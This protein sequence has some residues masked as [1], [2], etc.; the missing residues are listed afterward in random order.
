M[1]CCSTATAS[2]PDIFEGTRLVADALAHGR[3]RRPVQ[4]LGV[5]SMTW[6]AS[7]CCT[8]ALLSETSTAAA[9]DIL[10][11]QRATIIPYGLPPGT[12]TAHKTGGVTSV[13]CDV[14]IVFAPSAP[15]IALMAKHVTDGKTIDRPVSEAVY[16]ELGMI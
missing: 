14:G 8:G 9:M 13:R 11:R 1:T 10:E 3:I 5:S 2:R 4:A 6:C 7:S 15:A 12:R 16:T